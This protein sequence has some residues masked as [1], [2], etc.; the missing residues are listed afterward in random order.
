MNKIIIY[1]QLIV[2]L[3]LAPLMAIASKA[4]TDDEKRPKIGLV[5][6]GGGARGAAHVGV[7]KVLEENRI[8]IDM[9]A[10]TSFG[11][12]VGGLYA[13][14]YSAEELEN[15]LQDIDWEATLSND[16][17]RRQKSFRRKQ[18]D[19]GFLI[20]FKLG[21][22]NWK[23]NLPSGLINPNNLRLTL[24]DI[25]GD[26]STYK[27]FDSLPIPFRAVATDLQTGEEVILRD[28]DLS[29]ALVSSM[30]VPALFPP[31][32][33][34]D[35]LLVD[36][37]IVNNI[38]INIARKM[39]ADYVIVVDVTENMLKKEELNTFASVL[40]QITMI[41]THHAANE[42][43]KTLNDQDVLIRPDLG[44]MSMINF[45]ETL[46]SIPLGS[47]AA[48]RELT[49]LKRFSVD[50]EQWQT[51]LKSK[52][53]KVVEN[54]QVDFIRVKNDSDIS[55]EVI[56]SHITAK[57][58]DTLDRKKLNEDLTGL[59]GLG[60]FDEVN[61]SNVTQNGEHGLEIIAKQRQNGEDY[62]RFGLALQD[63]FEGESG[64]QLAAGF[65]NLAINERGGELQ[66]LFKIGEE[67]GLA[68]EIYQPIDYKGKYYV[69]GDAAGIKYNRNILANNSDQIV[70]QVRISTA[71]FET[72][73]GRNF[74]NW[75]TFRVGLQKSYSSIVGRVGFPESVKINVDGTYL[76]ALFSADTLDAVEFP[77]SG[78][79]VDVVYENSLSLFGG[80][81]RIDSMRASMYAPYSWGKNTIGV[82]ARAVTS[83]NGSPNEVDIF[84]LG[85]FL[86][87][88]AY[89]PGQITGNHG[90][91]ATLIYYRRVS[92][93]AR[94]IAGTP[95][96]IGGTIE[97]GNAWN[98]SS[99]ISLGDL[100][101]SSSLFV[102]ADTLLGPVYLGGGIGDGGQAS[103]FLYVG[104]LF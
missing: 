68:S 77:R 13:S 10:G 39:G 34:K 22:K 58:G 50:S 79:A 21:I 3:T 74:G 23:I 73:L 54:E 100:K 88:T 78:L 8:P 57:S 47:E 104:Q 45:G 63:N 101:W 44:K 51:Y 5:L 70:N 18:D 14:G 92:G 71:Q 67:F 95:I 28:G 30:A 76:T 85:G 41:Q 53:H 4:Q 26:K 98:R 36:G 82:S 72:G 87:L 48:M 19:S 38:P 96:Y 7:L 55:N 46:D 42:Q 25:V 93:D 12:I 43:L 91:V 31:V 66:A 83:F 102:G 29:F 11:A 2:A 86:A 27:D 81:G 64:Y 52:K 49:R 103:A 62:F 6:S 97:A 9:I 16:A 33:Y 20:K 61:Y 80:D 65:T 59:Y 32:E 84:S 15:I 60:L 17:P 75:A 90:G 24:R 99:D 37:G 69:Y 94:N 1:I 89:A 56:M 35:T 40:D